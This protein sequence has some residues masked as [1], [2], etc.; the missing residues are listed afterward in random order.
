[1]QKLH[2]ILEIHGQFQD[3]GISRISC[4]RST[5]QSGGRLIQQDPAHGQ[6]ITF[7]GKW[8]VAST[9]SR[10]FGGKK[11]WRSFGGIIWRESIFQ[12]SFA[13]GDIFS[14]VEYF[15][16]CRIYRQHLG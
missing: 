6:G 11:N 1:M 8:S 14:G 15:E 4:D 10:N 9:E 16:L 3:S 7:G 2:V 13:I 12:S 5:Y